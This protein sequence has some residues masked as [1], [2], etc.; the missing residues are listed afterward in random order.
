[1]WLLDHGSANGGGLIPVSGPAGLLVDA[2]RV[3]DRLTKRETSTAARGSLPLVADHKENF[4][5]DRGTT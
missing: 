2:A 3:C 5:V 1:M 4:I